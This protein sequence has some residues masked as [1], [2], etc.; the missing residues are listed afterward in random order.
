M[1]G[2]PRIP[3]AATGVAAGIAEDLEI[4]RRRMKHLAPWHVA[5]L[6]QTQVA[7]A[8]AATGPVSADEQARRKHLAL[9]V[10]ALQM[11]YARPTSALR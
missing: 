7:R 5:P 8:P 4:A 2:L 9:Q 1:S 6:P 10:L 3:R 11:G